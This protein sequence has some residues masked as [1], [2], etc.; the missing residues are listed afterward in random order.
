M[1]KLLFA[2]LSVAGFALAL[3]IAVLVALEVAAGF[4][5]VARIAV[6]EITVEFATVA[7][8]AAAAANSP[9]ADDRLLALLAAA[10]LAIVS[11]A[12]DEMIAEAVKLFKL[13]IACLHGF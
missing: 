6:L 3:A 13:T 11:F 10:F 5:A 2:D 12:A 9:P 7:L 8:L 1:L 4:V